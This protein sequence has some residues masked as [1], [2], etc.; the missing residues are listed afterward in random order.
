MAYVYIMA[1]ATRTIY[2]G[3]TND[4]ERRVWE[5][6]TGFHP[7]AFTSKHKLTKLVYFAEFPRIADAMTLHGTGL[8]N[9]PVNEDRFA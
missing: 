1:N 8:R 3:V 7:E 2:T 4:L 9:S 6:R 5:H